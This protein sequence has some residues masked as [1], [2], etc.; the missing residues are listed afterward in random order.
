[1]QAQMELLMGG[2]VVGV[3]AKIGEL[4]M[5]NNIF[6][7]YESKE[8][9][10]FY[11]DVCFTVPSLILSNQKYKYIIKINHTCT[12]QLLLI[13][14]TSPKKFPHSRHFITSFKKQRLRSFKQVKWKIDYNQRHIQK[15]QKAGEEAYGG[16]VLYM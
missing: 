15:I 2:V 3:K 8:G 6:S 7:G 10:A 13:E 12:L 14:M 11:L 5:L 1:M 4:T 9:V 16:L